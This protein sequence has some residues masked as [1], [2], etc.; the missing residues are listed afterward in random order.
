[1]TPAELRKLAGDAT[2]G[3][4]CYHADG[5]IREGQYHLLQ[6]CGSPSNPELAANARLA[7]L[8]PDLARLAA[9]MA[10]ALTL[11]IERMEAVYDSH[12]RRDDHP[13]II[14][15]QAHLN[16]LNWARDAL[17]ARLEALT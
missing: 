17:L 9:D 15:S 4:W 1:M 13:R 5:I 7:A 14:E 16:G 8:A 11:E 2:D 3:P 12:M 6:V 10:D